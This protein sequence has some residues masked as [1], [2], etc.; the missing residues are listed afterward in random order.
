MADTLYI[1]IPCYNESEVI[2]LTARTVTDKLR[3]FIASAQISENSRVMFVNDRSTDDTWDKIKSLYKKDPLITAVSLSHNS[4]E[5]NAYLAGMT[6]SLDAAD[7]IITTDADL[8]DDINAMDKMLEY[9]LAGKDVVYGVRERRDQDSAVKRIT[10]A[11]FY[12]VMR[13]LGS[14]Q[15]PEHS[16][17]RLMSKKAV[18]ALLSCNETEIFLPALMPSLGFDSAVVYHNRTARAAGESKYSVGKLFKLSVLAVFS[19]TRGAVRLIGAFT[20]LSAAFFL[21][22]AAGIVFNLPDVP[23]WL[24]YYTGIWAFG[25]ALLYALRVTAAYAVKISSGIKDRPRFIVDERLE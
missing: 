3:A 2:E 13:L 19:N 1:V 8:Q 9:Y 10:A 7:V 16:Q 15:I 20:V 5:Q 4:G 24:C 17:Y 11:V 23:S 6:A 18:R 21:C 25:T 14:E 22:G 12:R